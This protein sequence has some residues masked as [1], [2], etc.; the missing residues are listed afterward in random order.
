ML[1]FEFSVPRDACVGKVGGW[2]L[3]GGKSFKP[4]TICKLYPHKP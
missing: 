1:D 3:V 4:T 2:T